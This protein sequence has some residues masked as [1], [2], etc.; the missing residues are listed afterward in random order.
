MCFPP[1]WAWQTLACVQLVVQAVPDWRN[2]SHHSFGILMENSRASV[3]CGKLPCVS[4]QHSA[5]KGLHECVCVCVFPTP[6]RSLKHLN[7]KANYG[8]THFNIKAMW[9]SPAFTADQRKR[10]NICVKTFRRRG[11]C[12]PRKMK[13][14]PLWATRREAS[15]HLIKNQADSSFEIGILV[16]KDNLV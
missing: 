10:A 2:S 3:L 15:G 9:H 7:P 8:K 6:V 14:V 12:H 16:L 1:L 11:A 5:V 13:R 4:M